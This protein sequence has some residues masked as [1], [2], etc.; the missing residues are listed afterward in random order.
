MNSPSRRRVFVETAKNTVL[1]VSVISSVILSALIWTGT[2]SDLALDRVSYFSAPPAG[3]QKT[4]KELLQPKS[5]LFCRPGE[6]ARTGIGN[7]LYKKIWALLKKSD[8]TSWKFTSS[9]G[10]AGEESGKG[11]AKGAAKADSALSQAGT[12]RLQYESMVPADLVPSAVPLRGMPPKAILGPVDFSPGPGGNLYM[13][14]PTFGGWIEG[15]VSQ[16]AGFSS[17]AGEF[18]NGAVSFV[19]LPGSAHPVWVPA[20]TQA[21]PFWRVYLTTPPVRSVVDSYFSDPASVMNAND[22]GRSL[23]TDGMRAVW[24]YRMD[25]YERIEYQNPQPSAVGRPVT[26]RQSLFAAV[27]FVNEHGGFSGGQTIVVIGQGRSVGSYHF[28]FGGIAGGWP[29]FGGVDQVSVRVSGG[30]VASAGR[31]LRLLITNVAGNSVQIP[32]GR[33]VLSHLPPQVLRDVTQATLG[34]RVRDLTGATAELV[35]TYR[36]V[37]GRRVLY[38]DARTGAATGDSEG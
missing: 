12:L 6:C 4:V 3:I 30:A 17:L 7:P 24:I 15:A 35:P 32:P 28:S 5:M 18:S 14:F 34:Y 33:S 9:G 1:T 11:S 26:A 36:V 37:S 16:F 13:R 22:G 31:T 23:Y 38:L 25:G 29:I 20:G 27:R 2:P 10:G 19:P 21:M 8:L